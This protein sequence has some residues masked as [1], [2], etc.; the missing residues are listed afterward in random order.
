[1]RTDATAVATIITII[2]PTS[3]LHSSQQYEYFE[4]RKQKNKKKNIET[5][6]KFVKKLREKEREEK[7]IFSR[8]TKET[9]RNRAMN[10]EHTQLNHHTVQI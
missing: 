10:S 8:N 7:Q 4:R 6:T 3:W 9:E 5:I 1:M 2:I